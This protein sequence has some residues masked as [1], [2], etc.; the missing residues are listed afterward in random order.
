MEI[1]ELYILSKRNEA[2]WQVCVCKNRQ[3][4]KSVVSVCICTK[5]S[6][7]ILNPT[8]VVQRRTNN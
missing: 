7:R 3:Q 2:S 8:I 5:P 6:I 1:E 4:L